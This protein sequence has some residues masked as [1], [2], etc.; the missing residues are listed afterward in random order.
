MD[1][2]VLDALI[3]KALRICTATPVSL[4]REVPDGGKVLNRVF[5]LEKT[6]VSMQSHN[7]QRD[8]SVYTKPDEFLPER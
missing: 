2:P 5:M 6:V 3:A 8:F 4:Q 1:L 7:T